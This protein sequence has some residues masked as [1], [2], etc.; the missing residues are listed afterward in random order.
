[1]TTAYTELLARTAANPPI[2]VPIGGDHS[3]ALPA[4]RALSQAHGKPISV[5]HF[6]ANLDTWH[7]GKMPS[8]W[9]S[10][11]TQADFNHG[12]MFWI[13]RNEGLVTNASSVH[14]GLRTRLT[15]S[16]YTDYE[17]DEKQRFLQIEADEIDSV[18]VAGIVEKIMARMGR[19]ELVYLSVD[20]D[21]LDPGLAPGTGT[22]EVGGW[23]SREFI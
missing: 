3:I 23:T 6:D 15:G 11:P 1:M 10:T 22:P 5:L 17:A 16:D 18:G 14:A 7:P 8:A 13:A 20:I 19:E 4:L 21:V 12:S 9:L 2:L